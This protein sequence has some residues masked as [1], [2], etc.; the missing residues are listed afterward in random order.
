K[1][2]LVK[3][4][5]KDSV[6]AYARIG[7]PEKAWDFFRRIGGDYAMTMMEQL[8]DLYNAQ[9]QFQDS[10]KV[11]RNLMVLNPES[12]KLCFW[13]GEVMKNTLSATGSRASADNVK[14]LQRLGAVY[15]KVKESKGIKKEQLEE[16]RDT[17]KNTLG[18]LATVWHK[19]AQ[20]TNNNDTYALAQY[21]YKEYLTRFPKEKDVYQMTF[22]YGELLFKLGSN[23]DNNS[24][25]NAAPVYTQVVKMKPEANAK[26]LKEA[27]YAAV[28][29][30]KNCLSVEDNAQEAIDDMKKKRQEM[31][32]APKKGKEGD[33]P[34]GEVALKPEPISKNKQLMVDAFD[35]YIKYVPDSPELPNIK[36][37][38]ARIYYE[39]NRFADA[40]PL[41]K[42]I[43]DHHSNSELAYYSTNL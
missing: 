31:K 30:W 41:F 39:A 11:Y 13:Q 37:R 20:K 7:T 40:L 32:T 28:I 29:S 17:T 27:A 5:K 34:A 12:P 42:D 38:K 36:Y 2:A 1:I 18:E 25:C 21:L 15:E 35:T 24:Y 3:E 10:I 9:G 6:R 23:G 14:E 16:C 43:A 22:Y 8:G 4:A 26:Y 19:E 33:E